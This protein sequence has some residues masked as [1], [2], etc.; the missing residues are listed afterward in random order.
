MMGKGVDEV[1]IGMCPLTR[2]DDLRMPFRA[3]LNHLDSKWI[4]LSYGFNYWLYSDQKVIPFMK[5]MTVSSAWGNC[6]VRNAA[7]VPVLGD[8]FHPGTYV[9]QDEG[10]PLQECLEIWITASGRVQSNWADWCVNRHNGGINLLFMDGSV[11]KVGLKELW[12]L[13]WH[14]D[15]DTAGPWTQAGGVKPDAWP[16]WMRRFRDY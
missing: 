4:A 6:D 15:F 7:N 14:R 11:R 10:P 12:T 13:K 16:P 9:S 1:D 2:V 3:T 8:C 5:G